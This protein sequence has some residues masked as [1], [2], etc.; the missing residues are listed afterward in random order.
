[1]KTKKST[2]VVKKAIS[3]IAIKTAVNSTNSTCLW[4]QYQHKQP[5][6]LKKLK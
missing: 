3:K 2:A 5:I 4:F 1:M 6:A